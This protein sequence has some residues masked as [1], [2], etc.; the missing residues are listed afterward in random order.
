MSRPLKDYDVGYKRPPKSGQWK[1]GECGNPNRRHKRIQKGA[2]ELIE[3]L[4]ATQIDIAENGAPRR[5][6]VIEAIVLQL[7]IKEMSGDR[8]APTVRLK[9]VEFAATKAGPRK[10]IITGG[11]PD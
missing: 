4:F 6:S 1:K 10:L 8:R 2:A 11:L 5:V 9:Y 3:E 7:W